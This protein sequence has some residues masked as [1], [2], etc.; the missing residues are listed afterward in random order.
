[1]NT[2]ARII[3]NHGKFFLDGKAF[4]IPDPGG[5]AGR[6]A[7]P[8][9]TD[10]AWADL[11]ILSEVSIEPQTE[12]RPIFKPSPGR[13]RK[14]DVLETKDDL[15]LTL[16]AEELSPLAVQALFRTAALDEDS[17]TYKPLEGQTLKGWLQVKQYDQNDEL[18]NTVEVFAHLK[19]GALTFGDD[20]ARV[21]F[22]GSV[23]DSTLNNGTL[24]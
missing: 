21:E 4:T 1:M 19:V 11:G 13:L 9:D 22:T 8:G 6:E 16:R 24:A 2:A 14:Y 18:V 3:G 23:L 20:V 5:T 7:K 10:P 17:T 12:E 15:Q